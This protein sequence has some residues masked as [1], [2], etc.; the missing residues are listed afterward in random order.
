LDILKEQQTPAAFFVIGQQIEGNETILKRIDN[1]GHLIGNHSYSHNFWFSMKSATSMFD[2]IKKCNEE[3]EKAIVK[4]P[5]LFRPPY[6][7]TNPMVAKAIK[8]AGYT[9]IGWSL[10]TFDTVAKSKE[11]LLQKTLSN[12]ETGSVVLF[13]DNGPYTIAIL[14]DFIVAVRLKGFEI[15]RIDKL[16]DVKAYI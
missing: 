2:D 3:I 13:H 15:V 11:K 8:M 16:L 9:S 14:K 6:G 7:V 10:R 5:V 4:R 1:E 12:L